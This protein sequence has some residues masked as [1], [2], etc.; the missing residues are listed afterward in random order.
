MLPAFSGSFTDASGLTGAA[1][2]KLPDSVRLPCPATVQTSPARSIFKSSTLAAITNPETIC[3]TAPPSEGAG[4]APSNALQNP[5]VTLLPASIPNDNS[6][7]VP[8]AL[9]ARLPVASSP[10]CVESALSTA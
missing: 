6:P 9:T 2:S 1:M 5:M 3:P 7:A 10:A 8:P 4:T